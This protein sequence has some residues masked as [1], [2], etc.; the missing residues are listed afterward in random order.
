MKKSE[1]KSLIRMVLAESYKRQSSEDS[2][3]F[4]IDLGELEIPG[5]ST[6]QDAIIVN[7]MISYTF[8]PEIPARGRFGPP[9]HASPGEGANVGVDD[10]QIET[11]YII[12]PD[13]TDDVVNYEVLQPQQRQI[14]D[15]ALSNYIKLH[16]DDIAETILSRRM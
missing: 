8:E 4:E 3:E 13:D 16:Q 15:K 9:E 10:Y 6:A 12:H 7:C 1:L 14:L 2:M 11:F 5:V